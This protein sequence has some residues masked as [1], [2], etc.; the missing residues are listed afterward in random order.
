MDFKLQS[1]E[2]ER[3]SFAIGQSFKE[4]QQ[5]MTG[6]RQKLLRIFKNVKAG[7]TDGSRVGEKSDM[8]DGGWDT[9]LQSSMAVPLLLAARGHPVGNHRETQEFY[10]PSKQSQTF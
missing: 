6:V 8:G 9:M 1:E 7:L 4:K 5:H 3:I 10:D 2:V